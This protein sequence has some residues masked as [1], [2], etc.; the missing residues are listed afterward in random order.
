MKKYLLKSFNNTDFFD[1][2]LIFTQKGNKVELEFICKH[3]TLT[4]EDD[5]H[6]LALIKIRIELEKLGIRILCNGSRIDVYLSG[7]TLSTLKAYELKIGEPARKLL[8]IFEPTEDI[9]KIATINEQKAYWET[10]L[11]SPKSNYSV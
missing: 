11:D 7:M 10:W 3:C 6:F 2:V 9:D 4:A 8:N 5:F 1:S